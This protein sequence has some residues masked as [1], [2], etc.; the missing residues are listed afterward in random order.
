MQGYLNKGLGSIPIDVKITPKVSITTSKTSSNGNVGLLKYAT[1]GGGFNVTSRF[2]SFPINFDLSGTWQRNHQS[3]SAPDIHTTTSCYGLGAKG[4][5]SIKQ[6]T[7]SVKGKW[8]NI[9][10][11]NYSISLFDIDLDLRYKLGRFTLGINGCNILHMDD[12]SWLAQKVTSVSDIQT[13]YRRLPGYL[14]ASLQYTI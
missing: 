1:Y 10:D 5:F 6:F 7:M 11:T 2:H 14:L 9:S 3:L 13:R 8:D 4:I 12:N